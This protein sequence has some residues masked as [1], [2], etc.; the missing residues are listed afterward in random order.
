LDKLRW[1]LNCKTRKIWLLKYLLEIK[2]IKIQFKINKINGKREREI[3]IVINIMKFNHISM[4]KI[5][6][7]LLF[8]YLFVVVVIIIIICNKSIMQREDIYLRWDLQI[9]HPWQNALLWVP[10]FCLI[11]SCFLVHAIVILSIRIFHQNRI[12]LSHGNNLEKQK[13]KYNLFT[14][15]I[16]Y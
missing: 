15:M 11:F 10:F 16:N 13:R 14:K 1:L 5:K 7:L 6:G 12:F 4:K 8:I 3:F 2:K 9:M